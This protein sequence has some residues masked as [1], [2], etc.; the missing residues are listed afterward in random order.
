MTL[1]H[2]H[3]LSLDLSRPTR[4]ATTPGLGAVPLAN[5]YPRCHEC[6]AT[7]Y[8]HNMQGEVSLWYYMVLD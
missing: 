7:A 3:E 8:D 5:F 4:Q 6:V 1:H 2:A